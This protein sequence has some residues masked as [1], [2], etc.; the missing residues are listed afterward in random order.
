MLDQET[1]RIK[2]SNEIDTSIE[3]SS[4]QNGKTKTPSKEVKRPLQV[5]REENKAET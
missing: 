2:A 5:K 1:D 3:S 4:K